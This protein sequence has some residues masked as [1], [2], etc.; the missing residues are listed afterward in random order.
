MFDSDSHTSPSTFVS[1]VGVSMFVKHIKYYMFKYV[2]RNI[3]QI[4][5]IYAI[6]KFM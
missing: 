3:V 4:L 2:A 6:I 5:H 1:T